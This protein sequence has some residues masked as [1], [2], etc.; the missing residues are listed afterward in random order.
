MVW[1]TVHFV[2][3]VRFC[4]ATI[5]DEPVAFPS[6]SAAGQPQVES[7]GKAVRGVVPFT[8]VFEDRSSISV[9]SSLLGSLYISPAV[10]A[11]A[12]LRHVKNRKQDTSNSVCSW[13]D[14]AARRAG[15][16]QQAEWPLPETS[17]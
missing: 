4:I 2:S 14:R 8:V 9:G 7:C 11:S 13:P 12:L 6:C 16:L 10:S 15:I 5:S 17:W 1:S 3:A